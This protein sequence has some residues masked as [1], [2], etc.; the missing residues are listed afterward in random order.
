MVAIATP[1]EKMTPP[2]GIWDSISIMAMQEQLGL[3]LE[4]Q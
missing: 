3:Q 1:S 2:D 4:S